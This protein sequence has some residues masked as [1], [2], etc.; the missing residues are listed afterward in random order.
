MRVS[1][2]QL[3]QRVGDPDANMATAM[4]YLSRAVE[5]GSSLIV[6]P[7]LFKTGYIHRDRREA[8]SLAEFVTGET[9]AEIV[10]HLRGSSAKVVFGMIESDASTGLLYNSAVV[11]DQDGILGRYRKSHLYIADS[12][13]ASSGAMAP[14]DFEVDGLR[15]RVVICADIEFPEVAYS[16]IAPPIDIICLPTAWVDEKAPSMNWWARAIES[17]AS[18]VC[19]DLAGVEEG[20]QFSG[21]S[22]I[23]ALDGTVLATIDTDSGLISAEVNSGFRPFRKIEQRLF[24]GTETFS[25]EELKLRAISAVPKSSEVEVQ[26]LMVDGAKTSDEAE[27]DWSQL[28]VSNAVVD[29]DFSPGSVVVVSLIGFGGKERLEALVK[30]VDGRFDDE[31]KFVRQLDDEMGDGVVAE[32]QRVIGITEVEN[33][34]RRGLG[35]FQGSS[36]QFLAC[37]EV[38]AFTFEKGIGGQGEQLGGSVVTLGVVDARDLSEFIETRVVALNG[39]DLIFVVG[40]ESE[41]PP[42][43]PR[44]QSKI[45]LPPYVD[46]GPQTYS[47][48]IMRQ[49]AG[50]NS[51]PMV[52][53]LRD[54][55]ASIDGGGAVLRQSGVFGGDYWTFPYSEAIF[56]RDSFVAESGIES[57]KFRLRLN[58][59]KG[60]MR[61]RHPDLYGLL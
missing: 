49:R 34:G 45:D 47:F 30:A 24:L 3:E 4:S 19:A 37:G 56:G 27:E 40:S 33:Q 52:A 14:F 41:V 39:A 36:W 59:E 7:E 15:A 46:W 10:S 44:P 50:E 17:G 28:L 18:L 16:R 48:S 31:A 42:L 23:L 53:L 22:S 9:T 11:V 25:R 60:Y 20:V 35:V 43:T 38:E 29:L 58:V 54:D 51:T 2:I 6:L 8:L 13:W 1:A 55:L 32:P 5:E 12:L 57:L 21:G 26:L 61:R